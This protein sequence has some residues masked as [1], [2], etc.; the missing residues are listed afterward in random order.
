MTGKPRPRQSN[1]RDSATTTP[2]HETARVVATLVMVAGIV[3]LVVGVVLAL[4]QLTQPGGSVHVLLTGEEAFAPAFAQELPNGASLSLV[5]DAPVPLDVFE[6]PA[7]LRLLTETAALVVGLLVFAGA[8]QLR[9]VLLDIADGH[10]FAPAM[11]RRLTLIATVMLAVAVVP[12]AL[13]NV[14]TVAVLERLDLA[15]P[16]SPLGFT[17]LDI[18][19]GALLAAAVVAVIAQVFRHGA[20]LTADTE[21]LI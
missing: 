1:D 11:P 8:W 15:G 21:G 20:Q 18:N 3:A 19:L 17:I 13:D 4:N 14:A 5:A 10:P 9:R 7:G 6:L 2:P 16:G 12:Q